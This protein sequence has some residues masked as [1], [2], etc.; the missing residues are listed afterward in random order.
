M[1]INKLLS[2]NSPGSYVCGKEE[3]CA[4]KSMRCGVCLTWFTSRR[5]WYGFGGARVWGINRKKKRESTIEQ[6]EKSNCHTNL[7]K[8]WQPGR[9]FWSTVHQW[10]TLGGNG[11]SFISLPH[12]VTRRGL[13]LE[14]T[15]WLS[16]DKA[17]SEG[18]DS[19]R[20][21]NDLTP[22]CWAESFSL[23]ETWVVHLCVY[24][25]PFLSPL[26]L[27][28]FGLLFQRRKLEESC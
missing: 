2:G 10:P 26:L 12:S 15:W 25:C 23:R 22:L 3:K 20:L 7:T 27:D 21:S 8:P 17:D 24:R 11:W 13:S 18:T 4:R 6:R 19:W 14:G 5:Y 16:T 1:F 9:E 28:S